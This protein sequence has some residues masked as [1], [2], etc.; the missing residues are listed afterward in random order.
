MRNL[1]ER[2]AG[3]TCVV[4]CA[5]GAQDLFYA[6]TEATY[7]RQ[8]ILLWNKKALNGQMYEEGNPNLEGNFCV[9]DCFP[10]CREVQ[11]D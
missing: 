7:T 11:E 8:A 1:G 6:R 10:G 4:K 2:R 9:L 5:Y 3:E